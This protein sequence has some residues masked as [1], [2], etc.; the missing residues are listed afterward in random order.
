MS[1]R[2]ER[3]DH[4]MQDQTDLIL[5]Q[6]FVQMFS[7]ADISDEDSMGTIPLWD[8]MG[9]ME[10]MAALEQ[11]FKVRFSHQDIMQLTTVASI[12]NYLRIKK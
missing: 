7:A 11:N 9:H 5:K 6:V 4:S 3:S 12:K 8:S 1:I 2:V 10:L